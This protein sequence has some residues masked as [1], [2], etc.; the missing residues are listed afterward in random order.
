MATQAAEKIVSH[1]MVNGVDVDSLLGT[2]DTIKRD[3]TIAK[4]KF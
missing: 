1:N 4:F 2:I 3:P